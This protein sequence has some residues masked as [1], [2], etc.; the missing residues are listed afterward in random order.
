MTIDDILAEVLKAEGGYVN[1]PND[2]GG[3]T[4]F[5]IT[6]AVARAN[7]WQGRM[8][9]L[10]RGKALDIYRQRYVVGPGFDKV[11]RLSAA[12]AAELVDTGVNMGPTVPIRF[13][14]RL[15]NVM[16]R[17][18][19][20]WPDIATDGVIGPGTLAALAKALQVRGEKVVLTGL[21]ALQGARYIELAEGRSANEQFLNGWLANRVGL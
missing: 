14:Q 18:G 3:E 4:N 1:D 2:R 16:N 13:L 9:D 5:G 7:G 21:N 11:L 6:V 20:D 17:Q 12:I 10:P 19:K 15:L 8:Q